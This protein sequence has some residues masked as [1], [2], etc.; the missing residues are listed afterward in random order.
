[1]RTETQTAIAS[2]S[3]GLDLK[4]YGR[5]LATFVPKAIETEEENEKALAVIEPLMAKGDGARTAEEEILLE[6]LTIL[7]ER[8]EEK[9]YPARDVSPLAALLDLMEHNNLKAID[10]VAQLGSRARASEILSGKR[11]ISKEQAKKLGE[12]FRVSPALF[13]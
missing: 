2:T 11:A 12:R 5:L 4:R 10:L 7:V 3:A 6:L 13:I 1:M 8:Y 9:A